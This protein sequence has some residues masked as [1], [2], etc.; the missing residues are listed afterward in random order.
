MTEQFGADLQI[1]RGVLE[2]LAPGIQMCRA[3]GDSPSATL[4]EEIH[5]NEEEHID[6]L[7]TQLSLLVTLGEPPYLAQLLGEHGH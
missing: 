4:L 5:A 2:P 6:C 3:T 7:E 1:E